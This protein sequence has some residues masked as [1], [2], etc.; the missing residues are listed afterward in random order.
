MLLVVYHSHFSSIRLEQ[1]QANPDTKSP[2]FKKAPE[3]I[4]RRERPERPDISLVK[5]RLESTG[6][7][8]QSGDSDDG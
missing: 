3:I 8:E 1:M 4:S 7:T 6:Y 5:A 2:R